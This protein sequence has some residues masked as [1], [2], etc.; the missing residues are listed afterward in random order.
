[1]P[2]VFITRPIPD[3]GIKM[4][5]DK[6]YAVTIYPKD[7]IIPLKALLKGV[8]GVEALLPIL[9]DKIDEEVFQAAGTQL[10]IVANYAVGFDNIDL[11]AAK[12]RNLLVTNAP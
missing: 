6:G 1:M 3:Q 9:T 7:K 10:K 2:K 8:R 5:R 12:K 11:I 4:L